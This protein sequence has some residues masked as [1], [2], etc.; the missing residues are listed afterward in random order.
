M[1]RTWATAVVSTAVVL[2]VIAG[3]IGGRSTAATSPRHAAIVASGVL[4]GRSWR[5]AVGSERKG[6]CLQTLVRTGEI[7]D[8]SAPV[9][10]RGI[11]TVKGDGRA[12]H[13]RAR[14]TVI[15]AA[16]NRSVGT[17]RLVRDDGSVMNLHPRPIASRHADSRIRNLRYLAKAVRGSICAQQ[18]ETIGVEGRVL[19]Q[20]SEGELE[21]LGLV[22]KRGT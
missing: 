4:K 22:C 15:A 13:G 1:T 6:V 8:C 19:W 12:P 3:A 5:V 10:R 7:L 18:M 9:K 11:V 14:I 17:L 20:V 16:L 21:R 2:S